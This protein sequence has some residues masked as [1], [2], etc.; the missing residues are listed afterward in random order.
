LIKCLENKSIYQSEIESKKNKENNKIIVGISGSYLDDN[1][2]KNA[3]EISDENTEI[4]LLY[5]I[6][7]PKSKA[8]D[9]EDEKSFTKA[10][11]ILKKL[12]IKYK[13]FSNM[14]GEIIQSRHAGS[15][16]IEIININKPKL[17]IIGANEKE[18]SEVPIGS[19][20]IYILNNLNCPTMIYKK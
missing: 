19:N 6:I 17:L 20:A 9:I 8:L 12:E 4:C 3:I 18:K 10:E 13:K 16:I 7:I 2:I 11:N 5:V 15:A 14:Y 1:L